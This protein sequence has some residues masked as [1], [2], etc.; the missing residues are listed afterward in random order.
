MHADYMFNGYGTTRGDFLKQVG[1]HQGL[2]LRNVVVVYLSAR[3]T[4]GL[5]YL[6]I[7]RNW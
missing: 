4:K 3:N 5:A 2:L 7:W 6:L 1:R